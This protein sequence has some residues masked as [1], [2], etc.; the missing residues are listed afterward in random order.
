MFAMPVTLLHRTDEAVIA[1]SASVHLDDIIAISP[2]D[3]MDNISVDSGYPPDLAP[4]SMIRL[5]E[6]VLVVSDPYHKLLQYL[7][8][9]QA[10]DRDFAAKPAP[11]ER[12]G[13]SLTLITGG[14]CNSSQAS[15]PA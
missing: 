10:F 12:S 14:I 7:D 13:P 5:E 15:T 1:L 9:Y 8:A 3:K 4:Q 6:G 2:I 11:P